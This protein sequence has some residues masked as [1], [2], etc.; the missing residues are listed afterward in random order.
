MMLL[1]LI[2]ALPAP[3]PAVVRVVGLDDFALRHGHKRP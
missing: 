2:D 3:G 1:R